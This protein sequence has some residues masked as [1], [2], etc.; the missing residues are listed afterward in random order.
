MA[1]DL[2]CTDD[3]ELAATPD[4]PFYPASDDHRPRQSYHP[5]PGLMNSDYSHQNNGLHYYHLRS[6]LLFNSLTR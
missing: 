4:S 3:S 6:A 1:G 2:V 5:K